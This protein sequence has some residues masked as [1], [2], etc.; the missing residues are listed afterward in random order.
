MIS[1]YNFLPM[2]NFPFEFS[3]YVL[4]TFICA[5]FIVFLLIRGYQEAF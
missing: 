5:H 3:I 4:S 2:C 1:E